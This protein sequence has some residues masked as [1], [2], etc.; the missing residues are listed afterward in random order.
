MKKP[1][2]LIS[3]V[4]L[5]LMTGCSEKTENAIKVMKDKAE[6]RL[7]TIAGEGEVAIQ[8][9][10]NQYA[11]LKEKLVRMKTLQYLFNERLD[12]AYAAN[13]SR[14]ITL[15]TNH[16]KQLNEKVPQ[17]EVELREF[18]D[19]FQLQ[20]NEIRLLKD[21]LASYKAMGNLSDSL[22]VTSE[23]EKRGT[24]IQELQ[25]ILKEKVQRAKSLMNVNAMEEGYTKN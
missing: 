23:Y 4:A 14:R 21:E 6:S 22:G 16:V 5:L 13:D 15:Y 3:S 2:V 24:H 10:M 17:A 11:T 19:I 8:M 7:V 9:Y 25:G 20:K 18:Y 1:I 12:E